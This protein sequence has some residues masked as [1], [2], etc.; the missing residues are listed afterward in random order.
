[1]LDPKGGAD[2][3]YTANN[4][5]APPTVADQIPRTSR[6]FA[7]DQMSRFACYVPFLPRLLAF[8]RLVV[9]EFILAAER[10]LHEAGAVLQQV[11]ADLTACA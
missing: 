7:G 1:M 10:L 3:T 5:T 11:G 9:A 6:H 2:S 4:P 8:G